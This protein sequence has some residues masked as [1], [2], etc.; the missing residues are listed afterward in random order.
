MSKTVIYPNEEQI[1]MLFARHLKP[2]M[3]IGKILSRNY[4]YNSEYEIGFVKLKTITGV[5]IEYQLHNTTPINVEFKLADIKYNIP[6]PGLS[7]KEMFDMLKHHGMKAK[8]K[9][10]C[11]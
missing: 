10:W 7:H 5:T 9:F 6:C 2:F 1:E 4:T 8:R 3:G 11:D